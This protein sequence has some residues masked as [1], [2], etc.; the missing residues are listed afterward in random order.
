MS[1]SL[2]WKQKKFRAE[3]LKPQLQVQE[4]LISLQLN[5]IWMHA[6]CRDS[7]ARVIAGSNFMCKTNRICNW[8]KCYILMLGWALHNLCSKLVESSAHSIFIMYPGFIISF[9]VDIQNFYFLNASRHKV[10]IPKWNKR[11]EAPPSYDFVL[12][13]HF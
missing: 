4:F 10:F 13:P 3:E 11:A 5:L 9:C 12:I 2:V 8:N 7:Q 6:V 1:S